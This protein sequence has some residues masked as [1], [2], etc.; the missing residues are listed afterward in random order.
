[1]RRHQSKDINGL[2][3]VYILGVNEDKPKPVQAQA[4]KARTAKFKL[5]HAG[6]ARFASPSDKSALCMINTHA[7]YALILD[8]GAQRSP[9][10]LLEICGPKIDNI[11]PS[12][13][14]AI[15]IGLVIL[16]S[17]K[18][19]MMEV[20]TLGDLNWLYRVRRWLLNGF[21]AISLQL[22]C[23]TWWDPIGGISVSALTGGV[24]VLDDGLGTLA[25]IRRADA[26]VQPSQLSLRHVF[27]SKTDQIPTP[28]VRY[29]GI[30]RGS[31][32]KFQLA[33]FAW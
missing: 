28:T 7:W 11:N 10:R 15:Q 27:I 16:N 17:E 6:Q 18:S 4:I 32:V 20:D 21:L 14:S 24:S 12:I 23:A 22:A 19:R 2:L 1:M 31:G 26:K 29:T 3:T 5:R 8:P 33:R 9:H 30:K 13:V 25:E